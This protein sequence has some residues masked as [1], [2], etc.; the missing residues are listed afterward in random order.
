LNTENMS[1]IEI[2][3]RK[4]IK[5][6]RILSNLTYVEKMTDVEFRSVSEVVGLSLNQVKMAW[7][8]FIYNGYIDGTAKNNHIKLIISRYH[9]PQTVANYLEHQKNSKKLTFCR[10]Q[11]AIKLYLS[12]KGR[13][14]VKDLTGVGV[15]ALQRVMNRLQQTGNIIFSNERGSAD[16]KVKNIFTPL[17]DMVNVNITRAIRYA[18]YKAN[19]DVKTDPCKG[20][21]YIEKNRH[22]AYYHFLCAKFNVQPIY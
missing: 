18:K 10:V 19:Q 8:N 2:T 15:G 9:S 20:L 1:A 17:D 5:A 16:T 12:G 22:L 21:N 14:E 4:K 13:Y 11:K 3:R 7:R 6:V